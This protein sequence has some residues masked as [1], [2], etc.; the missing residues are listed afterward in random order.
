MTTK[1]LC[2][3]SNFTP[4]KKGLF[5]LFIITILGLQAMPILSEATDN[6]WGYYYWPFINYPMYNRGHDEGEHVEVGNLVKAT[7]SN[8]KQIAFSF[9]KSEELGLTLFTFQKKINELLRPNGHIFADDFVALHPQGDK[10]VK[11]EIYNY[12]I[13]V[14]KDGP[15]E[16][17]QELL[18]SIVITAKS[19]G[20]K[21]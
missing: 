20:D 12:P 17:E 6:R 16:A 15:K 8:G 10:I 19:K 7:L 18:K 21:Q 11:L 1:G 5:S 14:T 9:Q 2:M 4:L 3:T 13:V